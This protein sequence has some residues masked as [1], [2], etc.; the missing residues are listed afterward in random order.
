MS[1]ADIIDQQG[2]SQ[3]QVTSEE[4]LAV[5]E[6]SRTGGSDPIVRRDED[7]LAGDSLLADDAVGPSAKGFALSHEIHDQENGNINLD[8]QVEVGRDREVNKWISRKEAGITAEGLDKGWFCV[9]QCFQSS[10][11]EVLSVFSCVIVISDVPPPETTT[12]SS[13]KIPMINTAGED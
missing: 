11:E 1:S 5:E 2:P 7:A 9:S 12:P 10:L 8:L 13:I 3:N 6:L 4:S